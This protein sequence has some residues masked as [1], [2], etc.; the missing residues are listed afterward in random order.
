MIL[1]LGNVKDLLLR[2]LLLLAVPAMAGLI[3]D[4][5]TL[6]QALPSW[7]RVGRFLLDVH[8]LESL[9]SQATFV[10]AQIAVVL[11]IVQ[12]VRG[13]GGE[14]QCPSID[15]FQVPGPRA[16]ALEERGLPQHQ[17]VHAGQ[18]LVRSCA[19]TGR[20]AAGILP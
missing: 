3:I 12:F 6:R 19:T 1:D 2:A 13:Q 8:R 16:D 18:R 15:P 5:R 4:I 17:T 11:A 9:P 10:L 7:S 20:T 14:P